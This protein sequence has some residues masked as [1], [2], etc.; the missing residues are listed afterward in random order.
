[1]IQR[2]IRVNAVSPGPIS[3]PIYGKLGLSEADLKATTA[4]IQ[5]QIPAGRFGNP[6]EIAKAVVFLASDESAFTVGSELVI[7][8]GMSNL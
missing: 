3:T 1:L 8:G 7:D 2:G 6:S 4:T 5:N